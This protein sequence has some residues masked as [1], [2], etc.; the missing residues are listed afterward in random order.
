MKIK[1]HQSIKEIPKIIWNNLQGLNLNP[2]YKW[3][4][5]NALEKSERVTEVKFYISH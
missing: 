2:F 4:W 5:L 1:W 3:D